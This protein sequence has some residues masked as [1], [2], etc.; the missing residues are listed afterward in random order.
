[1]G[2]FSN[3]R[4]GCYIRNSALR[5]ARSGKKNEEVHLKALQATA[6]EI[7]HHLGIAR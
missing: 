1:M 7:N 5:C 6:A 4:I 3:N 2:N